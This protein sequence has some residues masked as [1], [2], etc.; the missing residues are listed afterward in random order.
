M[1]RPSVVLRPNTRHRIRQ[2]TSQNV[3]LTWG[4]NPITIRR[5][6]NGFQRFYEAFLS[7]LG[8]QKTA[9]NGYFSWFLS[10][11]LTIAAIFNQNVYVFRPHMLPRVQVF[12]KIIRPDLLPLVWSLKFH[13]EDVYETY[14]GFYRF[15][16]SCFIPFF[17]K[18]AKKSKLLNGMLLKYHWP[19]EWRIRKCSQVELANFLLHMMSLCNQASKTCLWYDIG[20]LNVH[21]FQFQNVLSR[22]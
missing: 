12:D 2:N 16:E 6:T 9:Q 19:S 22:L 10:I 18:T 17:Q 13:Q 21:N 14:F 4:N 3:L 20:K 11:Y 1:K 5:A 8:S 15:D 7:T